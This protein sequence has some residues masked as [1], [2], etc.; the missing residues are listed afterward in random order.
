MRVGLSKYTEIGDS[1]NAARVAANL[2]D[3]ELT[4]AMFESGR[5]HRPLELPLW[6]LTENERQTHEVFERR[7]ERPAL[8]PAAV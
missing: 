3:L 8:G 1:F 6:E 5:T 2:S 4:L 7:Y